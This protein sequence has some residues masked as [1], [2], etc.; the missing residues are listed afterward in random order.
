M[1]RRIRT[2][3]SFRALAASLVFFFHVA[4]HDALPGPLFVLR[5]GWA[6]VSLFFALSGF[7]FTYLYLDAFGGWTQS[8]KTFFLKR[9]FRVYPLYFVLVIV[10]YLFTTTGDAKNLLAHLTMT[11][12]F[13]APYR[14]TMIPPA[15][16]LSVEECFYL[17]VPPLLFVLGRVPALIRLRRPIGIVGAQALILFALTTAAW[18]VCRNTVDIKKTVTGWED[19]E[20]WTTTVFGRFSDFAYGIAAGIIA[21][22]FPRSI[23]FRSRIVSTLVFALG[24]A[25][26]A[27][28]CRWIDL[29][30]GVHVADKEAAFS[31]RGHDFG[32]AGGLL[33]LGLCGNSIFKPLFDNA[34]AAY[35]GRI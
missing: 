22:R 14:V 30:G 16:T 10:T 13:F 32:L 25:V 8:L 21:L 35:L 11:H 29:H 24:C 19:Y 27:E 20:L 17:M 7:L 23:I 33:V 12:A 34:A 4:G 15:W 18:S 6:G 5:Y 2:L 1:D 3:T 9:V 28:T 26:F 31:A